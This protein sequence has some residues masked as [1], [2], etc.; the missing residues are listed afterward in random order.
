VTFT[1]RP[2]RQEYEYWKK[3][4]LADPV[5]SESDQAFYYILNLAV[6]LELTS[7][8]ALRREFEVSVPTVKR[9]LSGE[10]VPHLAMRKLVYAYL[11]Y[12]VEK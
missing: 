10:N 2:T 4:A 8:L 6:E 12:L 9:W 1:R 7:E 3:I 11:D 5:V